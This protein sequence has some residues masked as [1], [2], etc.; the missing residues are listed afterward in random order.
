MQ[1]QGVVKFP[2]QK[3]FIRRVREHQ[4]DHLHVPVGHADDHVGLGGEFGGQHQAPLGGDVDIEILHG[5]DRI[6]AWRLAVLGAH[7]GRFHDE[8]SFVLLDETPEQALGHRAAADVTGAD[9]Q[10]ST[11]HKLAGQTAV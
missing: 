9:E 6:P 7:P 4:V 8:V 10:D 11:S 2:E 1:G 5:A 3:G